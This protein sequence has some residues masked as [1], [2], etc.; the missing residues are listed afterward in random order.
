MSSRADVCVVACAE[1]F[2]GDGEI[3]AAGIGGAV[4]VL[5]ARLARL[6]FE[7]ELLTH[8]GTCLLTGDVPALGE[9]PELVEGWLPFRDHLWLVLNGRRHVMLGASQIDRYGNSNISCIGDWA[10]PKAQL[11]GVRG[12]PGNTRCD[13]T[14]YWIPRHSPRVFVPEVDMVSGLGTDRGA[15]E[16]RRVVTNLAVL[17]FRTPDGSMRLVSVHPGVRVDE[18]VAATGF[19]LTIPGDVPRTREP[20]EEELLVL[21]RLDPWR[22]RD[23][24][25]PA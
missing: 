21:D 9:A 16:L 20:S 13:P 2:R 18:V 5:A 22:S 10:R 8:D 23:R 6:T 4:T 1:A 25:V 14:S 24:E 15:Y 19:D 3:L 12:A 11:L 7:P 17:D